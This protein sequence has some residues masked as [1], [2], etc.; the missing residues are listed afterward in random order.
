M[1]SRQNRSGGKKA[2]GNAS[3]S[4]DCDVPVVA[5][6]EQY[7]WPMY[8]Q[9][10]QRR[11]N[12]LVDRSH[13]T[14]RTCIVNRDD[15]YDELRSSSQSRYLAEVERLPQWVGL[16]AEFGCELRLLSAP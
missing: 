10:P 6:P 4:A 11:V 3:C 13:G 16:E 5:L 15:R 8:Q 14:G 9:T 7:R 1:K 2:I 12:S